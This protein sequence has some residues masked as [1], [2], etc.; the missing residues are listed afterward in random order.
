MPVVPCQLA[1]LLLSHP[2]RVRRAQYLAH[3]PGGAGTPHGIPVCVTTSLCINIY[4]VCVKRVEPGSSRWCY[5]TGQEA[6]GRH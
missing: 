3:A 5:P 1:G 4:G 6:A 2:A